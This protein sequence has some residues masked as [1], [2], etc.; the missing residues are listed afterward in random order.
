MTRYILVGGYPDKA[1]DKGKAFCEEIIKDFK[2]PVRILDCIFAR[3]RETWEEVFADDKEFFEKH[4][5]NNKFEIQLADPE[6][7]IRQVKW[8]DAIYFRGGRTTP[9]MELLNK[10]KG[11]DGELDGKT[12]AGTSAGANMIAKYYYG[13]DS[14]E[15]CNGLGLLP[16]KVIV[17]WRSD[18]NAPNI[19]WDKAHSELKNY[20]E[21]LP[22]I[23]LAEGQYEVRTAG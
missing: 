18:Y 22:I 10:S 15:L 13:L 1:T 19:N 7:F 9:L 17:H 11:W 8:A 23:T 14:L 3:P 12:L 6:K 4:L 20:K 2:E 16:I 21:D 5:P